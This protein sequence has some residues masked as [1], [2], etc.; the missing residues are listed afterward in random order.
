MHSVKYYFRLYYKL[1][2][3]L[4]FAKREFIKIFGNFNNFPFLAKGTILYIFF[5]GLVR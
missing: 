1:S 5:K 2:E 4:E 3:L